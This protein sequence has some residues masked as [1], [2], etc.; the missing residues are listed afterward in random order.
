MIED[1]IIFAVLLMAVFLTI[2][3][4]RDAR[5]WIFG[6]IQSALRPIA[7]SWE[8]RLLVGATFSFLLLARTASELLEVFFGFVLVVVVILAIAIIG[9]QYL[10][11]L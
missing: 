4:C 1:P 7:S 9:L 11:V 8:F 3:F 6:M 2:L 5:E 10:D